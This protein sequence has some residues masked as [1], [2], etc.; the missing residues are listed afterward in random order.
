MYLYKYVRNPKY[1]LEEGYIR[2]TQLSVLNDPF[3]ANYS[4]KAL[5]E[6]AK[7][8][9]YELKSNQLIKYIEAN[10]HKVGV[11]SFTEA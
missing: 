11:V 4:R 1:I 3:E 7:E 6:L 8:F 9:N 10:K 2:A 5:K